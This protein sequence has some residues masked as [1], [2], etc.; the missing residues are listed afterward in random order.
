M[1]RRP[2]RST[3]TDTLFPYTTL[4][5]SRRAGASDDVGRHRLPDSRPAPPASAPGRSRG[6]DRHR[7]DG[8]R[9]RDTA[10]PVGADP[11]A[12]HVAAHRGA[13]GRRAGGGRA[14]EDRT[15]GGQGKS[16]YVRGGLGGWRIVKKKYKIKADVQA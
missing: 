14:G 16:V 8:R 7:A 5:R 9:L 15:S 10:R 12:D 3:R 6:A 13:A 1:I 2:P 11:A 4:F